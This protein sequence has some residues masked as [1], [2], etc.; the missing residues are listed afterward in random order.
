MHQLETQI[1]K[2]KTTHDQMAYELSRLHAEIHQ[3]RQNEAL[4]SALVEQAPDALFALDMQGRFVYINDVV[5]E[6]LGYAR[7]ELLRMSV[8]EV[9][10]GWNAQQVKALGRQV[11]AGQRVHTQGLLQRKDDAL[12]P[13]EVRI[14]L[15][16]AMGKN[17]IYGIAR[18]VSERVMYEDQL[19]QAH[20]MEAVGTLAG[21]VAHDF[22]NILGIILGCAELASDPLEENHPSSEY[23]QEI[24]LS[25]RRA[26]EVVRQLLN[27]S[28]KSDDVQQP[29]RID[30]LVK[31]SLKL[32]RSTTPANIEI[33]SMIADSGFHVMANPTQIHQVIINL[34]TN[35]AHA[36]KEGGTI[37]V[38]LKNATSGGT[39]GKQER[40][41]QLT[42]RDNGCGIAPEL[43]ARIF[44]P[45]FTTKDVGKGSGMGLAVVHG[46]VS[47][48]GGH[49]QVSSAPDKGTTFDVFLP[50]VDPQGHAP[51]LDD[52]HVEPLPG[53][54]ETILV[55]DDE[56][57]I[58]GAIRSSLEALGYDVEDFSA[59]LDALDRLQAAPQRFDLLIT[60]MAMPKMTG[61]MLAM[62]CRAVRP[63]L[64]V[65][66]CTGFSERIEG[67]TPEELD[68]SAVLLKPIDLKTL[69]LAVRQTLDTHKTH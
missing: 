1:T 33:Q 35:A 24:R 4:F 51:P 21:G 40:W 20:K 38:M 54:S 50:A 7:E 60:D 41:L 16:D 34:F 17:L 2:L 30:S 67:K 25:V 69:A 39:E 28:Q 26:K 18:D 42:V 29:M 6:V 27:F 65:I 31:Q 61:D 66:L 49:I 46:I 22:N 52:K 9:Q 11:M 5:C 12:I 14:G 10:H 59:P 3:L 37:E 48:H 13:V 56:A 23:L 63:H 19:R 47:S 15:F 64:P 62:K 45:Y 32:L 58:H 44:E 55:V 43:L 53:G 36:T 68:V 8:H 57:V